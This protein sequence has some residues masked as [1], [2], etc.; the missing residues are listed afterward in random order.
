M[1]GNQMFLDVVCP[2]CGCI[3]G[4]GG[5]GDTLRCP[6][7]HVGS[8]GLSEEDVKFLSDSFRRHVV[9]NSEDD[10]GKCE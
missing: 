7:G 1:I 8:G 9:N 6:C 5:C 4:N 10:D 3:C 2:R